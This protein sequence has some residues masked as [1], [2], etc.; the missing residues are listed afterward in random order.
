MARSLRLFQLL[1]AFL[2]I[3]ALCAACAPASEELLPLE[4]YQ[5]PD[6]LFELSIPKGWLIESSADGTVFT[7]TPPN[8]SGSET[9]LRVL[10]FL[11]STN[12]IDT[13]EHVQEANQLFQPFLEKYLDDSYEVINQGETKV[14]KVP[15]L[16]MDFA[17]PYE[18]T[19]LT[20]RLVMVAVPGY[21]LA[22]LGSAE[23][24]TWDAFLPTFRA[25]LAD[26]HLM[27]A[28][29]SQSYP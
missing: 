26:F 29:E 10:I 24:G 12:T 23:R 6:G 28:A 2:L 25:M 19:F 17:K 11:S 16:L 18:N 27:N 5:Q 13:G 22:F 7:L 1:A 20:G 14:A 15:A 21:A 9:E 8:Y 3:L 4:S